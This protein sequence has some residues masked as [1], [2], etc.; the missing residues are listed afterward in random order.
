MTSG[1]LLNNFDTKFN[2]HFFLDRYAAVANS[3]VVVVAQLAERSL[4]IPEVRGSNLVISE[5]LYRTSIY[6]QCY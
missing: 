5:F 4:L 1:S 2:F 6:F 3:M